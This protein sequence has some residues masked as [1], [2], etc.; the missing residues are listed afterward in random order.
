MVSEKTAVVLVALGLW[1]MWEWL[2]M[3]TLF[4]NVLNKCYMEWHCRNSDL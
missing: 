3:W 1:S 4:E 2:L